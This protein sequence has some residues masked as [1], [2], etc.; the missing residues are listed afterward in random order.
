MTIRHRAGRHERAS[1]R[2]MHH[3]SG[4]SFNQNHIGDI[5]ERK[6]L[7]WQSRNERNPLGRQP[8]QPGDS[9]DLARK[10]CRH[11]HF[12]SSFLAKPRI[13]L[14]LPAGERPRLPIFIWQS[15]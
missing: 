13:G 11:S 3:P 4:S 14:A 12:I 5:D 10:R 1:V 2:R 7:G 9:D 15:G 8:D 6:D